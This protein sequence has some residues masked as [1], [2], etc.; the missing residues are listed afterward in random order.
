MSELF[1]GTRQA[2]CVL[3]VPI[4]PHPRLEALTAGEDTGGQGANC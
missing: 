4:R 2:G 1:A 3:G